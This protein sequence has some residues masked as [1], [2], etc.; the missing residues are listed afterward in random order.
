MQ[1]YLIKEIGI[2]PECMSG[3]T[4]YILP[5][6]SGWTIYILPSLS[7]WTIYILPSMSDWTI[8]IL[9]STSGWTIYILPKYVTN[10]FQNF[11]LNSQIKYIYY[12]FL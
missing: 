7:G 4:I 12:I 11:V 3:W 10:S 1:D 2:M 5:S 6:M 9:P 8:Y